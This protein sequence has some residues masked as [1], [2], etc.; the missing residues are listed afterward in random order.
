MKPKVLITGCSGFIGSHLTQ[1]LISLDEFEISGVDIKPS[2]SSDLQFVEGDLSSSGFTQR[3]LEDLEPDF[4]IHL[5]S[6]VYS[7]RDLKQLPA[8]IQSTLTPTLNLLNYMD[9]QR[10]KRAIFLGSS[11]E[12]GNQDP[13]LKESNAP[14]VFSP[15][16]WAKVSSYL[17]TE[18][19][20]ENREL[21]ISWCRPFLVFG[22]GQREPFVLPSIVRACL[23][24]ESIKLSPGGQA[25]DFV[26]VKDLCRLFGQLLRMDYRPE[27][28][29]INMGTGRGTKLRE[30]GE[31]IKNMAGGGQ[32]NW[33]AFEYRKNEAM[34]LVADTE[35]FTQIFKG[36]EWTDFDPALQETIDWN[37]LDLGL[38]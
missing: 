17:I 3:L 38:D 35:L 37:R 12:Y 32:L 13:P 20:R 29:V 7:G 16:S 36:F 15:Y 27:H 23:K 2:H 9:P 5:A 34:E 6:A 22:P 18:Y 19:F 21:P 10:V 30:L 28:A 11:D 8:Q 25:R 33:S 31:K 1:E 14:K 24:G 4:I 26:Y